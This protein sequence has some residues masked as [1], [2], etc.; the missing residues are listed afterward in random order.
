MKFF[1]FI[2]FCLIV[3]CQGNSMNEVKVNIQE[4]VFD[5]IKFPVP[6]FSGNP[7]E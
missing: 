4:V 6:I 1:L 2:I 5:S 3:G 7:D